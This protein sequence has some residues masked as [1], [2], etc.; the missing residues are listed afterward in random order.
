MIKWFP[1]LQVCFSD[2][3]VFSICEES[4][5]YV[6]R[7]AYE[8]FSEQ[9]VAQTVKHPTSA[10]VWS[11]MSAQGT[12]RL[13]I[14][15]GSMNQHQYRK[16]LETRLLPQLKDW[17]PEGDFVFMHDGAPCHKAKSITKFLAEKDVKTLPWPGYSPDMN[18]IENLWGIVKKR[19]K[20]INI[21]TK[22]KLIENLIQIW[23]RDDE[24]KNKCSVL[25]E[26]MPRRIELLIKN[27][28]MHTKY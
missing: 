9:C 8:E 13:Y 2:E 20:K 7:A 6:R 4:S 28:G 5:Q 22:V 26:S 25:I 27:K 23:H 21:T 17:F 12:G 11:I 14:V 18:P 10:M 15:E 24:I 16:V 3:S 1:S 19:L